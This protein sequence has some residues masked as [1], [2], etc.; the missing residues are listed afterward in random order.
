[1]GK[2]DTHGSLEVG[3]AGDFLLLEA[4]KWEHLIYQ[5]IDPPIQQV[6]LVVSLH[7]VSKSLCF[8][9]LNA[10]AIGGC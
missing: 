8:A 4:D 6:C 5:Q 3:K 9:S 1:M 10:S 7:V 2:S